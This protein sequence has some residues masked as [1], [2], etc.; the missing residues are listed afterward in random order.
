M[1]YNNRNNLKGHIIRFTLMSLILLGF[2]A[3]SEAVL[4]E[5]KV[6]SVTQE[7]V[8]MCSIT[9][10]KVSV[11]KRKL[12]YQYWDSIEE[13]A[14]EL[15]AKIMVNHKQVLYHILATESYEYSDQL[16]S[17]AFP[18]N[19]L[20]KRVHVS[21]FDKDKS[22]SMEIIGEMTTRVRKFDDHLNR[23]LSGGAVRQLQLSIQVSKDKSEPAKITESQ[24]TK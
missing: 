7:Q 6:K 22:H 11:L 12:N 18:C 14:P 9:I 23:V 1:Y 5:E 8:K 10:H 17:K 3:R 13:P 15:F 2:S 16:T 19:W 20:A 24:P 21:I 4:P